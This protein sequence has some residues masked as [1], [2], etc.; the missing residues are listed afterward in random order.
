MATGYYDLNGV[1]RYGESDPIALMSDFMNLGQASN[2]AAISNDRA[3]ISFLEQSVE[4]ASTFVA[5]SQASRD[6]YWGI[7]ATAT[8]RL[9]LQ[10]KG[11]RTVRTDLG[12]TQQYFAATTDGGTNSGGRQI[13]G[14]YMINNMGQ[15]MI[16]TTVT[17]VTGTASANYEGE[18]SY[19]GCTA[20]YIQGCFTDQFRNYTIRITNNSATVA[21]AALFRWVSGSTAVTTG[22]YTQGLKAGPAATLTNWN[23]N[24]PATE[25]LMCNIDPGYN[26]GTYVATVS[27]F[28][29]KASNP[30][31]SIVE[32]Y[33]A[34]S[35]FVLQH[36]GAAHDSTS[37]DGFY[38]GVNAGNM[39][40]TVTVYGWN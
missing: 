11:A 19:T 34:T 8:A 32:A 27:A 15:Q 30:S 26:S 13:A 17:A 14:W 7:P 37:R 38:I 1:Y 16:P 33:S 40:G 21:A 35:S 12:V 3:R 24:V 9:A 39:T 23:Y 4:Q 25:H 20:V 36:S 28:N 31:Y 29:P 22:Y 6:S 2:S 18:V 10:N 5:S